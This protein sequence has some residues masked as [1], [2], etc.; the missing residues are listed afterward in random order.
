[1]NIN[2]REFNVYDFFELFM[3]LKVLHM[4]AVSACIYFKNKSESKYL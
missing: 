2:N 1:M 4:S 3:N